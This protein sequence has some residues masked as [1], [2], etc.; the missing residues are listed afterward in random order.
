[1]LIAAEEN[2]LCSVRGAEYF[3]VMEGDENTSMN[4]T[5]HFVPGQDDLN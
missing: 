3:V 1:M 4:S 5:T 2:A